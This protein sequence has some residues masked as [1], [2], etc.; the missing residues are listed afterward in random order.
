MVG[1]LKEEAVRTI[2]GSILN[3]NVGFFFVF[4]FLPGAI[5]WNIVQFSLVFGEQNQQKSV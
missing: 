2:T 4:F 3:A 5:K 1:C